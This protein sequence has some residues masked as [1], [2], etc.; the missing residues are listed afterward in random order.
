MITL[1]PIPTPKVLYKALRTQVAT[2]CANYEYCKR[3]DIADPLIQYQRTIS[4]V[5]QEFTHNHIPTCYA[6]SFAKQLRVFMYAYRHH[7]LGGVSRG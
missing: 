2:I 1:E 5:I 6:P 3:K 4:E 7:R